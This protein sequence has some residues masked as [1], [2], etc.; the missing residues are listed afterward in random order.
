MSTTTV[1]PILRCRD[2]KASAQWLCRAFGFRLQGQGDE[3]GR[4]K[5]P[6]RLGDEQTDHVVLYSGD[7]VVLLCAASGSVLD[8]LLVEPGD[9][10]GLGTQSCYITVEDVDAHYARAERAGANIQLPPDDDGASGRFYVCR[11]PEGHLWC[12][13]T[14]TYAPVSNHRE[15]EGDAARGRSVPALHRTT[16]ARLSALNIPTH[17]DV[18]SL[19]RLPMPAVAAVF[20]GSLMIGA[21]AVYPAFVDDGA[22]PK[23]M[24]VAVKTETAAALAAD[25]KDE[26]RRRLVAVRA[27]EQATQKAAG[28]QR[29]SAEPQHVVYGLRTELSEARLDNENWQQRALSLQALSQQ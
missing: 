14:R 19:G 21:W 23:G 25:L 8:S 15:T 1:S 9:V 18:P 16:P 27:H 29:R 26:R 20:L 28:A 17:V 7:Y 6:E 5:E 3:S 12:F 2:V 11:D 24:S 13:G 10:G 22:K 4:S